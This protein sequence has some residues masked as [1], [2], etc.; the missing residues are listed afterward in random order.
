MGEWKFKWSCDNQLC[1][2]YSY[3]KLLES[4]NRFLSYDR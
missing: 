1:L 2:K 4:G 3:Q